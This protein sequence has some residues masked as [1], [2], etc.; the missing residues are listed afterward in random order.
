MRFTGPPPAAVKR[1]P[2]KSA[3]PLPSSN[4]AKVSTSLFIPLPRAAQLE[5]SHLAIR[6]IATPPAL[7]NFPPANS[8]SPLP[9]SYAA[10]VSTSSS[11]PF[12]AVVQI[13]PSHLR[14]D[15]EGK[16]PPA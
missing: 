13:E 6:L 1:P 9:S 5:P 12:P 8:A 4:T 15:V 16:R 14:I 10:R 11:T 2:A 7:V 3:G